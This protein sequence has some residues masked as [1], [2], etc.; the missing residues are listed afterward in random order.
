MKKTLFCAVA[1]LMFAVT[2]HAQNYYGIKPIVITN[3][4]PQTWQIG[5]SHDITWTS[6]LNAKS[7]VMIELRA[8]TSTDNYK[9]STSTLDTGIF[10]WK[11]RSKS[12]NGKIV[13]AGQYSLVICKTD[14]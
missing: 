4:I 10:T 5:T 2:V 13:P 7:H 11:T 3:S 8:A 6:R 9:I 14:L 12:A 1:A